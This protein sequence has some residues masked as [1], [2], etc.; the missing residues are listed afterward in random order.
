MEVEEVAF[1]RRE[2]AELCLELARSLEAACIGFKNPGEA[3]RKFINFVYSDRGRD[4]LV[5]SGYDPMRP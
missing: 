2:D 3:V 5:R 1:G 4:I